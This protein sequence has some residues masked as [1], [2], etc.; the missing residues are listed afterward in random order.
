MNRHFQP[1]ALE[2]LLSQ[3]E[4]RVE[5]NLSESGVY[6]ISLR[7]LVT[8][9]L[10]LEQM[11]ST[12]LTYPQTD[13]LPDLRERIAALYRG[14]SPDNVLVTNGCAEANFNTL[15]ALAGPGDEIAVMRPNY[16]QIWGDAH[17]AGMD[18]RPFT[19]S[20]ERRWGLDAGELAAA[21]TDRTRLI[22]VSNPNNPTGHILT[23]PEMAHL[24][25]AAERAGA[26][27]LADEV[28]AGSERLRPD[29]T[30]SFWGRYERV[31][32][33]GGLSKAYGLPGLRIGW[34][35]A[36]ASTRN[37]IWARQD[38]TTIS[39]SILSNTL[40]AIALSATVR[41]RL[42]ERGRGYVRE[43]FDLLSGWIAE[44]NG[45]MSVTPPDAGAIAFV[46]YTLPLGSTQLCRRLLDEM[47]VLTAPGDH[48]G[49]D[50]HLRLN[51]GLPPS[52]V[53]K[54]LDRISQLLTAPA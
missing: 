33:T 4:N 41:D 1:F 7:E 21:V 27:L 50:R 8:D 31:V 54:G 20:E 51:H 47:D 28:Y 5:C 30:P 19:L 34:V 2:R 39:T 38:Y 29:M 36:P 42:I 6:P 12:R 40:A 43:G 22:A 11:L 13:G 44:H 3:W 53:K 14:A 52:Y 10:V 35:V 37:E 16:M 9:P 32:I 45:L 23:E 17:N 18:V 24:V 46:R 25:A 15:H 48:F 49:I 26:W